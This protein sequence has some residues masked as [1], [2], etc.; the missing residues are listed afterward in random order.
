MV[1]TRATRENLAIS[2]ALQAKISQGKEKMTNIL[3][4]S[5]IQTRLL[6]Y[7]YQWYGDY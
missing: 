1:A 3:M 2:K 4:E 5:A 7:T 6:L